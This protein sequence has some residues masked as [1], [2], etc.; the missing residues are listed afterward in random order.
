MDAGHVCH[1]LYQDVE[2]FPFVNEVV[3]DGLPHSLLFHTDTMT[4]QH[5]QTAFSISPSEMVRE[6]RR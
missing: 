1:E 2:G 5:G 3:V 6:M 4:W